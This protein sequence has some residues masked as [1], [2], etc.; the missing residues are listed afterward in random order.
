MARAVL[1][2]AGDAELYADASDGARAAIRHVPSGMVCE[3]PEDGAFDLEAFPESAANAGAYCS[4]AVDEVATM[5]VAVRFGESTTLDAAF[6]E[7]LASS[8]AQASPRP[9]PGAPSDADRAPPQGLPHFRIARFEATIDGTPHYLRVAMSEAGGW[10]L[11]QI[12][13][14]PLER[15]EAVEAAA[16]VQWRALLRDFAAA[17]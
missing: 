11:Q 6:A 5:L 1:E 14:A 10:Y 8:A 4:T 9:W 17:N 3:L 2:R 16:G 15:A 13:S 12:V 7:A